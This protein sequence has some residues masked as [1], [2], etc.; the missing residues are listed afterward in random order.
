MDIDSNTMIQTRETI[1]YL[2]EEEEKKTIKTMKWSSLNVYV[3]NS[4]YSEG[5]N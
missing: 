3:F 2:F 1:I 5:L 4:N